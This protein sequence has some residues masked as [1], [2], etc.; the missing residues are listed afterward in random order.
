VKD[1]AK[2]ELC[3]RSKEVR[4]LPPVAKICGAKFSDWLAGVC[5]YDFHTQRN[6]ERWWWIAEMGSLVWRRDASNLPASMETLK[7]TA[8]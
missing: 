2:P 3:R 7:F 6:T 4:N 5:A 1:K 8:L